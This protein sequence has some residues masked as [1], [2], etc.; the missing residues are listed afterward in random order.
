[1]LHFPNPGHGVVAALEM[2]A[3]VAEAGLPPAHVGLHAGP[4]I[5]QEGDYFGQTVNLASRIAEYAR[6]GE[7]IV[8][9][10]VVDA[11]AATP[12]TF[13]GGRDR[14]AQGRVRR[15]RPL[16]RVPAGLSELGI[17]ARRRYPAA[18]PTASRASSDTSWTSGVAPSDASLAEI[19][20]ASMTGARIPTAALPPA[21]SP[22]IRSRS[23]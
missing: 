4:V 16:R 19:G 12:V 6:P 18:E 8:S 7:V 1:M 3:A 20:G 22:M 11:S 10:A 9:R 2:V 5:F 15:H 17:R 23:S 14:G 13:A 21:S